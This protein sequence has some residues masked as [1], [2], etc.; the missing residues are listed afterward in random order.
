MYLRP[1]VTLS[2]LNFPRPER[3]QHSADVH[4]RL[5]LVHTSLYI[6]QVVFGLIARTLCVPAE[7]TKESPSP[8]TFHANR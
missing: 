8:Q 6:K 4:Q 5:G 3:Q 2:K 7:S 1:D